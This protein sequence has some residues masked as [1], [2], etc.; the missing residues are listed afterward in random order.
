MFFES[1]ELENI[2]VEKLGE[3]YLVSEIPQ[4]KNIRIDFNCNYMELLKFTGVEE[5]TFIGLSFDEVVFSLL[6]GF[7]NLE[8]LNFV[9]CKI[10]GINNL[11]NGIKSLY[12][13]S[14][15]IYDICELNVF[16][17]LEKLFLDRCGSVDLN[18]IPVIRNT[19]FL[20]FMG[21]LVT[22]EIR[23]IYLDR[24]VNLCL[25]DSGDLNIDT[26][27]SNNTLKYLMIDNKIC[28][29]NKSVIKHLIDKKGVSVVDEFRRNIFICD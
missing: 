17:K 13:D 12:F 6:S 22:N 4:I 21:T 29:N 23:L 8:S 24:I 25:V 15:E 10:S 11:G 7:K 14:C 5:I 26:L 27:V 20:S 9:N 18:K 2:A 16:S 3:D 19:L 28:D 1:E